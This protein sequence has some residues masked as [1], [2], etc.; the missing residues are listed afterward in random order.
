[1]ERFL[2][3][4]ALA[5]LF[6]AAIAA[7][8]ETPREQLHTQLATKAGLT[9]DQLQQLL[10][11]SPVPLTKDQVTTLATELEL[12]QTLVLSAAAPDPEQ[13]RRQ[14]RDR[15]AGIDAIALPGHRELVDR[16][17]ASGASVEQA[18][19]EL[20]KAERARL[21]TARAEGLRDRQLD[22]AEL[23]DI[24]P[25]PSAGAQNDA[26][27]LQAAIDR[28]LEAHWRSRGLTRPTAH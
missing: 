1:M 7:C 5:H 23:P 17:K 27:E 26:A 6:V 12:D 24:V 9:G 15:L 14:E 18:A 21:A 22:E 4:P 13:V 11:G 20:C 19:L 8:T 10:G 16:L 2:S 3:T 25:A 28:T